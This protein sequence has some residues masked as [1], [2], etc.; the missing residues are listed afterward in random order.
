MAFEISKY[1]KGLSAIL[2]LKERGV[3]IPLLA[4]QAVGVS[5]VRD[6]FLLN[7]RELVPFGSV[8]AAAVGNNTFPSGALVPSGELW[9]VWNFNVGSQP[10]AGA[11]I[12]VAPA[13]FVDGAA[14][15]SVVGDFLAIAANEN[16]QTFVRSPFWAGPGTQFAA[17]AKNQ[18]LAPGISGQAIITRLRV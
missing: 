2:G 1:A 7:D 18:V 5:D 6:L 11:S 14:V 3:G 13:L 16:A 17:V 12:T 15:I 4:E 9:Y 8:V 10:G